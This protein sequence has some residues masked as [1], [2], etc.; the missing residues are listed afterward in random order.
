M[1]FIRVLCVIALVLGFTAV[2]YAETQSVKVSGDI[3]VRGI[4]R[5]NYDYVGQ[6]SV[7]KV[8]REAVG[9]TSEHAAAVVDART[10]VQGPEQTW[11]M[12]VAALQIDADL[13]DNVSTCIR[14][15]NQRDWDRQTK[16]INEWTTL[17]PNGLGGYTEVNGDLG[18]YLDLAYVQLKD[19]IYSPLTLTIGRQDL[20]FGKGFIVGLNQQNPQMTLSAPE[21]TDINSFDAIKAVLDYN[22]WT[23]TAFYS[24]IYENAVQAKD[25]INLSGV[26]IG[27]KFDQYKAEAET[28]WFF[29]ADNSIEKYGGNK[30]N[31]DV[32]TMGLRG[33]GDPIDWI[34]LM[35][36]GALQFGSYVTTR[37]QRNERDRS[38]YAFD[39]GAECRYF[40]DKFA[41]KPKFGSEFIIYSANQPEENPAEV[42]GTYTGWN[43]MYRGKFDS[44]IREFV[45]RYYETA[46]YPPNGKYYKSCEDAA[47]TNQQQ[48]IFRGSVQPVE[49]LTVAANYNLFWNLQPYDP[50]N[51]TKTQGFLGHELDI[52]YTWDYTEDVSFGLLTGWFMPGEVYIN[53]DDIATDVVGTVKVSF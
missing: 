35:G 12:S 21:Y 43:P 48:W 41:W 10:G 29:K 49:S 44:A 42:A 53:Q 38:A 26:N 50:T 16:D 2:A 23:I 36:E 18:I 15:L 40:T 8:V 37:F 9:A 11:I 20:W 27:Y 3:T 6:G 17:Y 7:D 33:S 28:Y 46:Q 1:R 24:K 45:G 14:I 47:F 22:P 4:F 30:G 19:F 31:N 52:Q 39:F 25:D 13:T 51:T 34:T 5:N 32:H